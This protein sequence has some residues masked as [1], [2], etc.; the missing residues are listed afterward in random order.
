MINNSDRGAGKAGDTLQEFLPD[1]Q[2][3]RVCT[4]QHQSGLTS[5][6]CVRGKDQTQPQSHSIKHVWILEQSSSVRWF[7][8]HPQKDVSHSQWKRGGGH[9][10]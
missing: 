7:A 3:G 8:T 5:H 6:L 9:K 4:S 2:L 10:K 1:F